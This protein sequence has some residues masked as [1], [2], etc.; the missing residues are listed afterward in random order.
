MNTKKIVYTAIFAALG[1]VIPQF[2]H[3]FGGPTAGA[4]FL[5]IH[6]PVFV[7]AMLLGPI[8]GLLI[9]IISLIVGVSLG[10]PTF[11][12]AVFLF[13]EMI[14]YGLVAGYLY[15]IRKMNVYLSFF[16]AKILGMATMFVF[17]LFLLDLFNLTVPP[18]YGSLTMFV[19][20]IPGIIIQVILVPILVV[21][22]KGVIK[23]E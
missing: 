17:S 13:F 11:S 19:I 9:A 23:Y 4:T 8:S 22:L 20:G 3:L 16:I 14:V 6:L 5:P 15:K 1:I 18:T 2:F 7:G 21:R 12:I 10:M